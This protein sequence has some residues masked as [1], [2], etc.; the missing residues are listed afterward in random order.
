MP[1]LNLPLDSLWAHPDTVPRS[2]RAFR[3]EFRVYAAKS[4]GRLEPPEGGTPNGGSA[5]MRPLTY[6]LRGAEFVRHPSLP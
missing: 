5:R 6:R 2:K 4:G 3:S 1:I